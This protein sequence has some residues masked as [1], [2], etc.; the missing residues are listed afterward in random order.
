MPP[1]KNLPRG[2]WIFVK[3]AH[4]ITEEDFLAFLA[5]RGLPLPADHVTL[6]QG[7]RGVS[8]IVVVPRD[9]TVNLMN[10]AMN[11]ERLKG[12][13]PKFELLNSDREQLPKGR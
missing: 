8:G 6:R 9:V 11:D 5:D 4:D 10:W 12:K 2:S 1:D 13:V 3:L 7:S